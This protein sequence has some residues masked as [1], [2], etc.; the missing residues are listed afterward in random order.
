MS[1]ETL[2]LLQSILHSQQLDGRAEDFEA[3]AIA[4]LT[5]RR[6]LAE[7]IAAAQAESA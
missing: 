5:A 7:A 4:V 2:M 3:V 1:L 6:E